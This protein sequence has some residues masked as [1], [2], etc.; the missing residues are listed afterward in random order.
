MRAVMSFLARMTDPRSSVRMGY[1]RDRCELVTARF[2]ADHHRDLMMTGIPPEF[3]ATPLA[4]QQFLDDCGIVE[5]RNL[6]G[7]VEALPPDRRSALRAI[8]EAYISSIGAPPPAIL[9]RLASS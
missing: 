9:R 4:W 3:V 8:V 1:R 7:V 2:L 6:A 5:A